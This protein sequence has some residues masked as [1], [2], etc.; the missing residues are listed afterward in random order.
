MVRATSALG[1]AVGKEFE[2]AVIETVRETVESKGHEIRPA[3]LRNGTGN[4]YQID[5]V[6]F[7][8]EGQPVI[9]IDPKYIRYTKH[10]RDKGS[11]LC[12][13]HYNLRKTH[14]S[15]RKSIAVLGGRWSKTSKALVQ[16]FGVELV[17]VPF[18][19]IA[20][21]LRR[22]RIEFDWPET[23]GEEVAQQSLAVFEALSAKAL[24]DI[25]HDMIAI[26]AARLNK[27]VA[28]VLDTD[29]ESMAT[30]VDGVEVLLKTTHGEIIVS[31]FN[32]VP[33]AMKALTDLVSDKPDIRTFIQS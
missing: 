26:V 15:I 1:E 7:N 22:R 2:L 13:A 18:E 21:V 12:V 6:V 23:G 20:A 17:E 19:H 5:A 9:I 3:R 31:S 11:W 30:R 33:G 16:S 8:A 25:R 28:Q 32:N 29:V 27:E 24:K 4:T 14:H 10:N